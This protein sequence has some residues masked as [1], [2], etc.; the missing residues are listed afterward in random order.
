LIALYI[1]VQTG[2]RN[3]VEPGKSGYAHLCEHIMFRGSQNY[4]PQQRDLI[5]K[6]AEAES[7]ATTNSD[8]TTYYETFPSRSTRMHTRPW[9]F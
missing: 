6:K 3:E 2:S 5:L 7:N 8:R 1:V 4:A 9:D